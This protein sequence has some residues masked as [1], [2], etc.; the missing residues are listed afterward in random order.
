MTICHLAAAATNNP[1]SPRSQSEQYHQL[2]L[3]ILVPSG[4]GTSF[5]NRDFT[6]SWDQTNSQTSDGRMNSSIAQSCRG[7]DYLQAD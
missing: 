4:P 2:C 3:D 7:L 5:S 1:I 6:Y